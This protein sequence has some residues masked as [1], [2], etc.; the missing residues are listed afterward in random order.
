[1]GKKSFQL[2]TSHAQLRFLGILI[3][4][5]TSEAKEKITLNDLYSV[6]VLLSC[7]LRVCSFIGRSP[8]DEDGQIINGDEA[9]TLSDEAATLSD[10]AA[11]LSDE[12]A[13]LSD[14][15]AKLGDEAAILNRTRHKVD[16]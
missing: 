8:G 4:F 3:E 16:Y 6:V 7:T 15:A 14:E 9:A 2:V 5:G 13:T 1:M 11:T 12:A 10:E